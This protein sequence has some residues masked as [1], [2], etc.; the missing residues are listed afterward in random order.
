M[1]GVLLAD[2]VSGDVRTVRGDVAAALDAYTAIV[3]VPD[4]DEP[5]P[6]GPDP[7]TWGLLPEHLAAAEAA[8]QLGAR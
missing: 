6:A 8:Q 4:P 1:L 5:E 3:N 7:E 2:A